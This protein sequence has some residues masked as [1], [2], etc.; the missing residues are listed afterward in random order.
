MNQVM[1]KAETSRIS[2]CDQNKL[3]HKGLSSFTHLFRNVK[4]ANIGSEHRNS[5]LHNFS[6]R[7]PTKTQK[8]FSKS[9]NREQCD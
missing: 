8:I 4:I 9:L 1:Y 2:I 3:F 6:L 7:H 5:R